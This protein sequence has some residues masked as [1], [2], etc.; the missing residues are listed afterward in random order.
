MRIM[1]KNMP[2]YCQVCALP[3][4][5]LVQI[6]KYI[7]WAR[8]DWG[9]TFS[10]LVFDSVLGFHIIVPLLCDPNNH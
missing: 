6:G 5:V 1:L 4:L 8:L 3:T 2:I 10:W 7:Q 9:Q